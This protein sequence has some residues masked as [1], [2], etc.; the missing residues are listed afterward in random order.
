PEPEEPSVPRQIL[1]RAIA[2]APGLAEH[3]VLGAWWGLR[4]STRDLVPAVGELW[5]GLV[6]ASG[7][8]G[9]GVILSGGTAELVAATVLDDPPP[10]DPSPFD[11]RRFG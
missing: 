3:P 6:V 10:F 7:H 8:G 5:P 4:P 9:K 11:P 2:L 1:R